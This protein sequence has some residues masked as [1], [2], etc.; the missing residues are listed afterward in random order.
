[1]ILSSGAV[2]AA[3]REPFKPGNYD[4]QKY[5][6]PAKLPGIS[7]RVHQK[8]KAKI[9]KRKSKPPINLFFFNSESFCF[10]LPIKIIFKEP[11]SF[12]AKTKM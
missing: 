1:M 9:E 7:H 11:G 3:G 10:A 4:I 5:L 6:L 12:I 2:V 8:G